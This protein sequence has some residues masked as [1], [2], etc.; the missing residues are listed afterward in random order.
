MSTKFQMGVRVCSVILSDGWTEKLNSG[1][2]IEIEVKR[3]I[4][5]SLS[6]YFII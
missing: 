5:S 3:R 1:L 2:N 4:L 6:D